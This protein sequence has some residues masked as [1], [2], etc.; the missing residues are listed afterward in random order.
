VFFN[1]ELS[2]IDF[3]ERVLAEAGRR[4][5]PPLERLRFVCIAA[6]N[7]DEFFMVRMAALKR[8]IRHKET[9]KDESG[10]SPR[11]TFCAAAKKIRSLIDRLYGC[12][13][14]EIIPAL[15][16]GGM[17]FLRPPYKTD[18]A[19]YLHSFF[20]REIVPVLTPLRLEEP[21]PQISSGRVYGAFLL[22]A[23]HEDLFGGDEHVSIVEIPPVLDRLIRLET[24]E[25]KLCWA[26]LDDLLLLWGL[27]LFPG[28]LAVESMTFRVH[29]DAD[30]SVDEQRDE[31]FVEAMEEV[32]AGRETSRAIRMVYSAEGVLKNR[33]A[34]FLNLE[35]E[36]M[37][38]I[39]GPLGL[40]AFRSLIQV[41]GYDRLKARAYRHYPHPAFS[42]GE[43]MPV[44]G[45]SIFD[46]LRRGDVL[47]A[48]PYHS[49]DPVV[50]FFED[51][52]ADPQVV[53]I[54][55]ALYRTSGHSPIIAALEQAALN[56]K[57][58]TAVVELKARFDEERN[59]IWANRLERAGVIVVY[60]LAHLK[61]HAKISQIIRREP[62]GLR[63][64]LHLSTG[65]YNDK[66]ARFYSDLSLFTCQGEIGADVTSLF[67][68]LTGYSSQ[69][70][71]KKLIPSPAG[72][73]V[74]LLELIDREAKRA[75]EGA[76]GKI[77]AKMN[78]LVD[79]DIVEAL[80]RAS[81]AGV[82]ILLN[83]RGI[84]TAVPGVEGLS[85]NIRIV[86]IVG[87][88]LEHSRIMYCNNGGAEEIFISSAD[89][90]P[91]NLERRVELLIPL[92]DE[93]IKA[94]VKEILES[95][96]KDN[97]QAWELDTSGVW[98]RLDAG[99]EPFSAQDYLT[100]RAACEP[101]RQSEFVVRRSQ[102]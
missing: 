65:N 93:K 92:L 86:S 48:L 56:G 14:D 6:S 55:T 21:P 88:Y 52:A 63:R 72:L 18:E 29:R 35:A 20:L 98:K 71:M 4:G 76:P 26:L 75:R 23:S 85:R 95:Y 58:V 40:A 10:L 51:A 70:S 38:F 83:V 16:K 82:N 101:Q 27:A 59:I 60:G 80:Y 69:L 73:K 30:F 7:L 34:A 24:S 33:L 53:S 61:I 44:S 90:M 49:F 46:I 45:E 31:D 62:D 79:R 74:K 54:K 66:T 19:E 47:L 15:E 1:R 39:G 100:R 77:M 9:K 13:L 11:E 87:H 37:D 42:G 12:F 78:A 67:N 28:Y 32:I 97:T 68:L 102:G 25:G 22:R 99:S 81:Q 64:Y 3:N 5:L 2:W 50:R 57:H 84:C 91:R 36:D 8:A 94:E 89:W 96:F 17:C 43:T 41:E